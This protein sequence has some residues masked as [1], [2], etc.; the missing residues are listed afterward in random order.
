MFVM[1]VLVQSGWGIIRPIH[2]AAGKGAADVDWTH[3]S[4]NSEKRA[5]SL[6]GASVGLTVAAIR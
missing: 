1:E 6:S 2:R 3:E 5:R 4:I